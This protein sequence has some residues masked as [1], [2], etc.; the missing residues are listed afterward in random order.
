MSITKTTIIAGLVFSAGVVLAPAAVADD[1]IFGSGMK[2]A[3]MPSDGQPGFFGSA[4]GTST[5]LTFD[6]YV[7][8]VTGQAAPAS[9]APHDIGDMLL[10]GGAK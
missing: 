9:P 10:P 6:D 8:I 3:T 1:T 2:T 4:L 7:K 5:S